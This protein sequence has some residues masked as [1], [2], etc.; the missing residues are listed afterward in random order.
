MRD[1][2]AELRALFNP[3]READGHQTVSHAPQIH[4]DQVGVRATHGAR[5]HGVHDGGPKQSIPASVRKVSDAVGLT[6][7]EAEQHAEVGP[8]LQGEAYVGFTEGPDALQGAAGVGLRGVLQV[9]AETPEAAL[10]HTVDQGIFVL[11]VVV[12]RGGTHAD[13]FGNRAHRKTIQAPLRQ[14]VA[15]GSQNR[16]LRV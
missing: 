9:L 16:R 10:D 8:V 2:R 14:H 11:E 7:A 1:S 15:R 4:H 5:P 3:T 6:R 12:E 13:A